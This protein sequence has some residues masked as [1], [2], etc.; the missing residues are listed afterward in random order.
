[1]RA[2]RITPARSRSRATGPSEAPRGTSK[3][4]SRGTARRR[5]QRPA[6][7]APR[8]REA[9][10]G[11]GAEQRDG[12]PHGSRSARASRSR[13]VRSSSVA[14]S[15]S[16]APRRLRRPVLPVSRSVRS[17]SR[18]VQR[19]SSVSTGSPVARASASAKARAAAASLPGAAVHVQREAHDDT[20]D[21]ALLGEAL[22][23]GE[24]GRAPAAL[25]RAGRQRH[26]AVGVGDREADPPAAEVDPEH[27]HG[28]RRLGSDSR[29]RLSATVERRLRGAAELCVARLGGL[30]ERGDGLVP[31]HP[32]ERR[33]LPRP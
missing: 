20:P 6:E 11:R 13:K 8:G 26:A 9:G 21:P 22:D 5:A 15:V 27:R 28:P 4:T 12:P 23:R 2:L 33:R 3:T 19:S 24:I 1:M 32:R 18:V 31:G 14:A 10:D 16:A 17:A 29:A 25:E 30:R 7:D